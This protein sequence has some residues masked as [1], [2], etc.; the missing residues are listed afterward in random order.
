MELDWQS[1]IASISSLV[2]AT[3]L[4]RIG[5]LDKASTAFAIMAVLVSGVVFATVFVFSLFDV[6]SLLS[7]SITDFGWLTIAAVLL[8]SLANFLR[9]DKPPFAR[10]PFF[11]TLL[12]L[13]VLPV[14]PFISDTVVIKNWVLALYQF[15]ALL[16][17]ALLFT[18][19]SLRDKSVPLVI[20]AIV[21]FAVAWFSKWIFQFQGFGSWMYTSSIILGMILATKS[22]YD[23]SNHQPII[24]AN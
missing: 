7:Q 20:I 19:V 18:L 4:I 2:A 23:K 21:M 15:G 1:L 13:I 12:P 16:I 10:Y 22:F 9:E 24:K 11:F 5:Y 17:A 8:V 3:V 14:F 6:K